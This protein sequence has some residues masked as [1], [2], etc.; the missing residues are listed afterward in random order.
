MRLR[1][2]RID[3]A[4]VYA[5]LTRTDTWGPRLEAK[6]FAFCRRKGAVRVEVYVD[7]EL[8]RVVPLPESVQE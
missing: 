4:T 3:T 7:D 1:Q 2:D 8:M 6:A 5:D